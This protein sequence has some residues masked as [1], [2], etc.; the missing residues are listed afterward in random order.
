MSRLNSNVS[1]ILEQNQ[2]S[3]NL[4][5]CQASWC[6]RAKLVKREEVTW[7]GAVQVRSK[8]GSGH[9]AAVITKL[10]RASGQFAR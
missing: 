2:L 6:Y 8:L 10:S 5:N 9:L 3:D 1:R 4:L 7:L